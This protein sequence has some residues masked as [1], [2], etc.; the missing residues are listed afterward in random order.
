MKPITTGPAPSHEPAKHPGPL[1]S[2][3]PVAE[4]AAD[5]TASVKARVDSKNMPDKPALHRQN[6]PNSS[7]R[8]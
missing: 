1:G 2:Q 6:T 8:K 7:G 5:S 3:Q 4:K